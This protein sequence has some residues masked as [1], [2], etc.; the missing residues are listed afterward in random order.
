MGG[1]GASRCRVPAALLCELAG[2]YLPGTIVHITYSLDALLPFGRPAA[3]LGQESIWSS[4][5]HIRTHRLPGWATP[6]CTC[7]P[8]TCPPTTATSP[9]NSDAQIAY[10]LEATW[11]TTI[12]THH[13]HIKESGDL[14]PIKM[15]VRGT[16]V[17]SEV[18]NSW[19]FC[20]ES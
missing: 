16:M 6:R 8:A 19:C 7:P 5:R 17:R 3:P 20:L 11:Q 2:A 13:G 12:F 9:N 4:G 10:C 18:C 15:T 14:D 1:G